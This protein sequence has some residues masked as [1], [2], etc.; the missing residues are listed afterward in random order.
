MP[1]TAGL[2]FEVGFLTCEIAAVKP[3]PAGSKTRRL[4]AMGACQP[5]S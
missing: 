3:Q 5:R 4:A 2:R 1:Q